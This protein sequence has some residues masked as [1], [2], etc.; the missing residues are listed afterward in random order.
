MQTGEGEGGRESGGGGE[1][2]PVF[3]N[4]RGTHSGGGGGEGRGG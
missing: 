1:G 2:C 4:R 3:A